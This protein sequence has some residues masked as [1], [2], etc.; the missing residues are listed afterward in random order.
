MLNFS[1]KNTALYSHKRCVNIK[2]VNH[3]QLCAW[4][5]TPKMEP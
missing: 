1:T 3:W 5:W 2:N 4:F